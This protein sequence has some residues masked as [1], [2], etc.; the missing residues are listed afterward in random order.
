MII[1]FHTEPGQ[2]THNTRTND[3]IQARPGPSRAKPGPGRTTD[4]GPRDP[5]PNLAGPGATRAPDGRQRKGGGDPRPPERER[6]SDTRGHENHLSSRLTRQAGSI[7]LCRRW[8][9]SNLSQTGWRSGWF[10]YNLAPQ[11]QRTSVLYLFKVRSAAYTYKA[12]RSC[13]LSIS[14]VSK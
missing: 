12:L 5:R 14:G 11:D 2:R 8:P 3:T 10:T 1:L 4:P 7:Y 13:G 6:G 9:L